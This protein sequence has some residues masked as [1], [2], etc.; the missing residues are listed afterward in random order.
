MRECLVISLQGPSL[1]GGNNTIPSNA[2]SS[3]QVWK[4]AFMAPETSW[5]IVFH[6]LGKFIGFHS[7]KRH[8]VRCDLP[9]IA[10]AVL[11]ESFRMR[12]SQHYRG[13]RG[14]YLPPPR[15]RSL[16]YRKKGTSRR[17]CSASTGHGLGIDVGRRFRDWRS[18]LTPM[19]C[20][21]HSMF[22]LQPAVTEI[23]G[24]ARPSC[25]GDSFTLDRINEPGLTYS[26]S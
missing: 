19:A 22:M 15:Q 24:Y 11:A 13:I 1:P 5:P 17:L 4:L 10:K 7:S 8:Y 23:T 21:V 3:C 20:C 14:R 25:P 18:I 6:R 2:P 12:K 16:R 26:L 9:E